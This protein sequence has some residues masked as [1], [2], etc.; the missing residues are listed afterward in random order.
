M[1]Y[2]YDLIDPRDGKTFYVGKGTGDRIKEHVR[3]A[4]R[5][6]EGAKCERIREIIAAGCAVEERIVREFDDEAVAYAYEKR[7]IA[8]L[9]RANLTNI[10]PGGGGLR[11]AVL[12]DQPKVSREDVIAV[13]SR[14]AAKPEPKQG[15]WASALYRAVV[16]ALPRLI[17]NRA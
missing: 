6:L 2:V 9:G 7:R 13:F 11:P 4:R 8:R 10:A 1:F 5:G 16:R 14:I 17:E 15:I 12:T 3:E